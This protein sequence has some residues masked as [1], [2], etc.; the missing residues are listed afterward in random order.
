MSMSVVTPPAAAARVVNDATDQPYGIS[1]LC[2]SYRNVRCAASNRLAEAGDFLK[3]DS[4]LFRIQ[5]DANS[6]YH[7]DIGFLVHPVV[8]RSSVFRIRSAI[9]CKFFGA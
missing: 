7:H 8:H 1:E 3:P 6:T 4:E 9:D 2:C 5:V